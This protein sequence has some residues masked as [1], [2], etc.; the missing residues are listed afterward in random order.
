MILKEE[1]LMNKDLKKYKNNL[2]EKYDDFNNN[3]ITKEIVKIY[4]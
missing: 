2:K 1:D 3:N 4:Y